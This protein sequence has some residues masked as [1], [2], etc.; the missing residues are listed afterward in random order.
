MTEFTAASKPWN[1]SKSSLTEVVFEDG[2]SNIIDNAFNGYSNLE[3]VTLPTNSVTI[4]K[5]AF[6]DT[7]W[8]KNQ[9]D[10][11]L[12]IKDHALIG[13][14]YAEGDVMI[15]DTVTEI[16]DSAFAGNK[17]MT[18]LIIPE[19]VKIVGDGSVPNSV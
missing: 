4:G 2:I 9:Y 18:S 8:I 13:G 12:Y 15:P 16:C 17:T 3:F 5:D 14:E 7:K 1:S 11:G 19:S 10:N 6:K